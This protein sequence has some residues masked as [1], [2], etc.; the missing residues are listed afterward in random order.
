MKTTREQDNIKLLRE[1]IMRQQTLSENAR[2]KIG[3]KIMHPQDMD[4]SKVQIGPSIQRDGYVEIPLTYND[5]E[6]S[7][8]PTQV[9]EPLWNGGRKKNSRRRK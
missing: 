3:D 9:S 5:E 6:I 2:I 7:I 4:L 1:I 8:I